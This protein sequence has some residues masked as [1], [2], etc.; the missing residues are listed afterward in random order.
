MTTITL[1]P[2]Q[3]EAVNSG[4]DVFSYA[5]E[6]LD[7]IA[8]GD[9]ASRNVAIAHHGHLLIEAPTG[10]GK[11]L[12]AGNVVERFSAVEGVVWFWFA[13]FKGVVGQTASSLK[14]L[15]A[16]L[17]LREL[18]TDR[19]PE[20]T[21]AGDVFVTTWATV[22]TR[23]KDSRNVRK[24][25]EAALS[26]D[27]MVEAIRQ[28]G[29]RIG[30]VVD[31][32]HHGF[33]RG[34]QAFEFF[35]DVLRPD[36]TIQITATPDDAQIAKFEREMRIESLNRIAISR[37]D[38]VDSGLIKSGVKCIAYVVNNADERTE[39]LVDFEGT[40]L[41]DAAGWHRKLK[42]QLLEAKFDVTPLMLVQVDSDEHDVDW[43]K[44]RLTK[45]GF[46]EEQIAVHTA[47][48]PDKDLLALANDEA[49][50][51]LIFKMAVALGFDCPRAWTLVSMR[52]ARDADFGVQLV[53][54]I[55]RVHRRLQGRRI[56]EELECGY[57]FLGDAESQA[58]LD[59]AGRRMNAIETAYAKV[60]P[61]TSL[62]NVGGQLHV[63]AVGPDGQTR[64]FP[65]GVQTDK[66]SGKTVWKALKG[67]VDWEQGEFAL[68]GGETEDFGPLF[69][70]GGGETVGEPKPRFAK[71]KARTE[72]GSYRYELRN[73]VPNR[74]WTETLPEELDEA[75]EECAQLFTVGADEILSALAKNIKVTRRTVEVFTHQVE[76]EFVKAQL[77]P[78]ELAV[79][80][81]QLFFRG[82]KFFDP[83]SLR[84][85]L[86][87]R[88][89]QLLDEKGLVEDAGDEERVEYLLNHILVRHRALLY[90]A[91]RRALRN[92]VVLREAE[93]LPDEIRAFE[94]LRA[95]RNNVY[96]VLPEGM[97]RWET[98]F[99]QH[100]DSDADGHILWWHRNEVWKPWSIEVMLCTG[101]Q[102]YPDFIVGIQNRNK[103]QNGLLVDTKW[104][105]ETEKET[106]KI[107]AEHAKYGRALI[108]SK[109][110]TGRWA[111]AVYDPTTKRGRLG[112]E[113]QMSDAVGF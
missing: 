105:I 81:E 77:S 50:E 94:R 39:K 54:R 52:A 98:E 12:M 53:G 88:F 28:S 110:G 17:R 92:H 86:T 87:R 101:R 4:L 70:S 5:K 6:Q 32:A 60:S 13:P 9:D 113:F 24:D 3:E 104:Q 42:Q 48:E 75:E 65:A 79:E 33:G 100:L 61:T 43:A 90:D 106:H 57:V 10:S 102:F 35:R 21:R 25:G 62:V 14:E 34:T 71:P 112:A 97:N 37:A 55:L 2:F 7:Q 38:A 26:V 69:P 64:L 63:Q 56:P 78:E 30:V 47:K 91:Q 22:A 49:R 41:E 31:E 51:V 83:R 73:G 20:S 103:E 93:P 15:F 99:A 27:D 23:M 85:A 16:G 68:D 111:P 82:Q 59:E 72:G 84:E 80:A 74:F 66:D 40:V 18:A 46:T 44:A 36:Y 58:G 29:L 45:L 67:E 1:K 109:T 108:L 19:S 76:F 95:S 8:G 96:G 89:Q 107:I 11:T